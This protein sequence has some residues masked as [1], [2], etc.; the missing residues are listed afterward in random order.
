MHFVYIDDSGDEKIRCY[1][2]LI[3][4]ESVWKEGYATLKEFRRSLKRSDGMFVTKEL[5]ATEFVAGRGRVGN[6]IV[7]KGRRCEL[8]RNTLGMIASL[9][10]ISLM[11]AIAPRHQEKQVFERLVNRINKAMAE[12]RSNALIIHDE[13]K[14][15]TSLVRRMSV[16]N[17]IRSMYG[18]WPGGAEY[19]NIPTAH[20]LEDIVFRQSHRS[21][22]IQM[23]DLCAYALFRNEYPL[24]SKT[25]Y[26]LDK[27]FEILHPICNKKAYAR[28][29]KRLGIIRGS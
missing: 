15:Y 7:P 18:K 11:N 23:A 5:H 6:Q 19:K 2:A 12:W 27:A 21:D 20:I 28:D 9:P 10:K 14:D 16:Y 3:L 8:F 13:G 26:G 22:F 24:P 29:P 1:S 25:K 4:H 17:P